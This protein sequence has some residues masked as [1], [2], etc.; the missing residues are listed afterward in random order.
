MQEIFRNIVYL[1][2]RSGT[3]VW[4]RI[5][6]I[7]V[8]NCLS[9]NTREQV[10]YSQTP[11]V[12]QNYY[13]GMNTVTVQRWLTQQQCDLFCRFLKPIMDR[14]LGWTMYEIDDLMFDGTLLNEDR[15]GEIEAK[16]GKD[17]IAVSIPLFNRGRRAFEGA[18]VQSNIKKMLNSADFVTVTTDHIKEVYH[19]LY[20]VPYENIVVV[21]N[22]L[23]RYLFGD[24]YDPKR[25]LEQFQRNKAK[26]RV[27][28]VS[29]LSHYNIDG[30]RRDKDGKA[31]RKGKAPDGGVVWTNQDGKVVPEAETIPIEDD[32]D[33]LVDCIRSTVDEFQWVFLGFCPPALQDLAQ[34]RKIE[35]YG[36]TTIMEYPSAFDRLGL[37]AV[38]AAVSKT[39]FNFCKSFIKTMETAALGIPC[40]ATRCLPYD[41]VMP[42][43]QLFDGG[44]ELAQKL[45][46]LKFSSSGV[47][48]KLIERQWNWLNSPCH[49]GDFDIKNFWL[50]D[51]I[52]V[53]VNMFRPPKRKTMNI[54][55]DLYAKAYEERVRKEA[56]CAIYKNDNILITK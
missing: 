16:Y 34:A 6:P 48:Q 33:L 51:N 49:E 19:D 22:F 56:E 15:R 45:R 37:Q 5:W 50:E 40:F 18:A 12:D 10:D 26:P 46:K 39:E 24:R 28:I 53:Y 32:I 41:R 8:L 7:N 9:Q 43:D 29:S 55:L 20:D 17:L 4:R 36:G 1:S 23:P 42:D 52:E 44:E 2:D 11:I 3:G 31:C 35:S 14:E 25:K 47:Y 27:G 21:P 13:K 38:V 30:V 54:V